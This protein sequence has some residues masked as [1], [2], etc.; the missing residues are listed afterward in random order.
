V[1]PEQILEKLKSLRGSMSTPQVLSLAGAFVGV[2]GAV[3]A[4]AF[5]LNQ[6]DYRLLFSDMDAESASA[7]AERLRSQDVKYKLTDG[8][9]A[10]QVPAEQLD[11][12]RLTFAGAGLPQSGRLGFELFDRTQFGATEFLEGITYRRA[13]EGE[14]ARTISTIGE[15]ASARVHI[16]MAKDSLFQSK[17]QPAKASVVL[18]LKSRTPLSASTVTGIRSLVAFAVEGLRPELVTI[19][20]TQGRPL[21]SDQTDDEPLGAAQVERQQRFERDLAARVVSMLEPVVGVDRVRVT[22]AARLNVDTEDRTEEVWDPNVALRSITKSSAVNGGVGVSQGIAGARANTPAPVPPGSNTPAAETAVTPASTGTTGGSQTLQ[23]IINNEVSRTITHRQRP[24]GDVARLSV[25]VLLD[26]DELV[27]KNADGTIKRERKPRDPAQLQQINGIVASA[28]GLDT[29]RGDQ[30]TIENIAFEQIVEDAPVAATPTLL[31]RVPVWG[32]IATAVGVVVLLGGVGMLVLK[33]RKKASVKDGEITE[34]AVA[35]AEML[36]APTQLPKTIEEI[37]G[38]IAQ[39]LDLEAQN[40]ANDRR[41]PVMAKRL[42]GVIAKDPEAASRL[43][44]SWLA[45]EKKAS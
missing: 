26:D 33:R 18:R 27:S 39:Q 32:W 42:A 29:Q 2:V 20:D 15:V 30:L 28:V 16:A 6:P 19:I 4:F 9:R 31:Q 40:N 21:T 36:P 1:N 23:E 25:A 22:I 24:R 35:G 17:E 12:L 14:I 41:V 5:W 45:D 13:L 44:R 8:G 43:V 37:E 34:G 3:I 7:V 38:E 10:I 11:E